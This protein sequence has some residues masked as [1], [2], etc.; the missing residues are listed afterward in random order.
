MR[1]GDSVA[2]FIF[3]ILNMSKVFT[4]LRSDLQNP[5]TNLCQLFKGKNSWGKKGE[6]KK[7][8]PLFLHTLGPLSSNNPS[9]PN[10]MSG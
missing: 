4:S 5:A 9:H 1:K 7:T 2:T 10:P 6:K 8:G 3:T